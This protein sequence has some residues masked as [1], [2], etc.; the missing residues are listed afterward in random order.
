MAPLSISTKISMIKVSTL[1]I[2]ILPFSIIG[3]IISN[4]SDLKEGTSIL[5]KPIDH[6]YVIG[7]GM[8]EIVFSD[9]QTKISDKTLLYWTKNA[10]LVKITGGIAV[11]PSMSC[12]DRTNG[13]TFV[14]TNQIFELRVSRTYDNTT[15]RNLLKECSP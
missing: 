13:N 11:N 12:Y 14:S 10:N 6:A 15:L 3:G 1:L 5:S 8:S 7:Y 4:E 2:F 9:G